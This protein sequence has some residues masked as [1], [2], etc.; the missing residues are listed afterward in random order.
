MALLP[1]ITALG[2]QFY[3]EIWDEVPTETLEA[4]KNRLD[5]LLS[6][7]EHNYSRF[8]PDS[9]IS[10]LNQQRVIKNPTPEFVALLQQGIEF[11]NITDGILNLMIGEKII[12]SGYDTNY[13]FTPKVAPIVIPNPHE[14]LTI[15]T[16]QI[17]LQAGLIDIGGYGKGV[18]IDYLATTLQSEFKLQ[19][20]LVNGGGDIFATSDHGTPIT[21]YLE[22]PTE[23]ATYLGTTTILNQGFA[24]SS[25]H[26]RTWVY[27]GTTYNHIIDT[28]NHPSSA[29]PDASF[30]VAHSAVIADVFA[31]VAL[32]AT[33]TQMDEFAKQQSLAMATFTLPSTLHYNQ[34]F[35]V[36]TLS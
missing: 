15:T 6:K 18:A 5:F 27:D 25:P 23:A 35:N 19:Y 34:A 14:V 32:L 33:P 13:S 8:I 30:V 16:E 21:I 11:Y 20:F 31:T 10:H 24:A 9:L 3:I 1:P 12:N 17:T 4:I 29:S 36:Q 26:K 22:H 7:F 28:V 2:T